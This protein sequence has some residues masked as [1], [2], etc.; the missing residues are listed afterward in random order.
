VL[1]VALRAL[2]DLVARRSLALDPARMRF[3]AGGLAAVLVIGGLSLLASGRPGAWQEFA[4][5]TRKH[6]GTHALNTMGALSVSAWAEGALGLEQGPAE[7]GK[8]PEP[9][10]AA[11]AGRAAL[12]LLFAPLVFLA[13]RREPDWAAAILAAAWIPFVTEL[14]SYYYAYLAIFGFLAARRPVVAPGLLVL[15]VALAALGVWDGGHQLREVFVAS[16]A[17]ILVFTVWL[18]ALFAREAS[19]APA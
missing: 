9:G 18:T 15:A 16:S 8:E 6:Y 4:E 19:D 14:G 2:A 3:V 17:C 11:R 10:V 7:P 12:A 1:G 5:N 13:L